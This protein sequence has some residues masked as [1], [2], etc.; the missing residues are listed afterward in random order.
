MSLLYLRRVGAATGMRLHGKDGSSYG[1]VRVDLPQTAATE[2]VGGSGRGQYLWYPS[3]HPN[4][5]P[6]SLTG[7]VDSYSRILWRDVEVQ[8][9]VYN[10]ASLDAQLV[11]AQ[12]RGGRHG[13]RFMPFHQGVANS[14]PDDV[15]ALPSTRSVTIEGVAHRLPDWNDNAY[16]TRWD[17]L[18]AAVAARYD[19][20]P[21]LYSIDVGG[22]GNW[23]EG[24]NWPY[25]SSYPGPAGQTEG[26]VATL[27]AIIRSAATR[28]ART[29]VY[30]NPFVY[31]V[32]GATNLAGSAALVNYALGQ[33]PRVGIRTDS[34]GGGS[35]QGTTI[36]IFAAAESTST[37]TGSGRPMGRWTIAP[38]T[39]EWPGGSSGWGIYPGSTDAGF[40]AGAQ[41]IWDW[42]VSLISN[43]N[44]FDDDNGYAAFSAGERAAF[45]D[46]MRAAGYRYRIEGVVGRKAPSGGASLRVSWRQAGSAPT[47][48]EWQ[49]SYRLTPVAGASVV[50]V[51]G[52]DLRQ[53]VG[54]F[55]DSV[56]IASPPAGRCK[57]AVRATNDTCTYVAPMRIASGVRSGDGWH[58][59]GELVI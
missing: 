24:H 25:E 22:Y 39:A 42:H 45:D 52:L 48:D 8:E 50:G 41:Q 1:I 47:Y 9:G 12:S 54:A 5:V 35:I 27:Q 57:V 31:R 6:A 4:P 18:M 53:K 37:A 28:F 34:I 23:G 2:Y 55:T 38:A 59:I 58:D 10:W 40:A 17:Q 16:L 33:S 44:F 30:Y 19:T 3:D 49:V 20:D 14:L 13:I 21:R 29:W 11:A 7:V 15:A 46:A 32:D 26:T 56:T 51:S 36:D 43:A